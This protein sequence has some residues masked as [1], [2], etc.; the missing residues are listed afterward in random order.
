MKVSK[1]F[2]CS[3]WR[4]RELWSVKSP[5]AKAAFEDDMALLDVCKMMGL[6]SMRTRFTELVGDL[7]TFVCGVMMNLV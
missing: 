1:S 3:S 7:D 5:E 4:R 2:D 6:S